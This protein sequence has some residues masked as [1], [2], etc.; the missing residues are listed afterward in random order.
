MTLESDSDA[1]PIPPNLPA[2]PS[3]NVGRAS[4]PSRPHA[5]HRD[6]S[7]PEALVRHLAEKELQPVDRADPVKSLVDQMRE[8]RMN[9]VANA[10]QYLFTHLALY[11]GIIA[12]LKN[13]GVDV[14]A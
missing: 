6:S 8:Q 11:A 4:S 10:G 2:F 7:A 3:T 1:S 12:D 13:E 14:T 9:S 5:A